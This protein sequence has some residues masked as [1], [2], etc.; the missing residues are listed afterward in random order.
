MQ[1]THCGGEADEGSLPLV[2]FLLGK[3]RVEMSLVLASKT[4]LASRAGLH[5]RSHTKRPPQSPS[6][7][8]TQTR[9]KVCVCERGRDCAVF[10]PAQGC[11]GASHKDCLSSSNVYMH[12]TTVQR[13]SRSGCISKP[14]AMTCIRPVTVIFNSCERFAPSCHTPASACP[15]NC[16]QV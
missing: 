2:C 14:F 3:Q 4:V 5:A 10:Q 9:P 16:A 1:I 12:S 13:T 15:A 7:A 6:P 8:I 11:Y